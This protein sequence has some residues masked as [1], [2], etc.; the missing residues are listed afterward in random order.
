MVN[1]IIFPRQVLIGENVA[2]RAGDVA[3][4]FSKEKKALIVSDEN[5]MK[6][7]GNR[8][9]DSLTA[10]GFK[11]SVHLGKKATL[12]AVEGAQQEIKR[13][14]AKIVLGIG[15]GTCIDIA[16][17]SSFREQIPFISV[18]TAPSHDGINSPIASIKLEPG[19]KSFQAA[20][21]I[22]II[23]D[24]KIIA[25]APPRFLPSGC[26]D[27][28]SNYTAV[29]DWRLA[30]REKGEAYDTYASALSIMSAQM[31]LENAELIS[32]RTIEAHKLVVEGLISSANAMCIAGTSRPCSGAE[33]LFSHALDTLAPQPAMHGEQCGVGTIMTAYLQKLD[34]QRFR[35][36]LRKIGAPTTAK[37]LGIEPRIIIK[38]LS[39]A[40]KIR[41]RYTILGKGLS[42]KE[43]ERVASETGVI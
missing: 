21:P 7:V 5:I 41:G 37:A 3:G 15:G 26:G 43:A 18:P 39:T 33:H 16:K 2:L 1:E 30:H 17:L 38:A 14:G 19:I 42:E 32:K 9:L 23:A 20:P 4:Q 8:I 24:L 13:S 31:I 28:V 36:A 40:H 12:S 11:A 27:L 6:I 35:D 34:W 29:E 10:H 22:A 25:S